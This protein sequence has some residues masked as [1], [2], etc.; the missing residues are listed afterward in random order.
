[1]VQKPKPPHSGQQESLSEYVVRAEPYFRVAVPPAPEQPAEIA[2]DQAG[3]LEPPACGLPVP[4]PVGPRSP[5][6][7]RYGSGGC[8]AGAA[9]MTNCSTRS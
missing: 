8:R 6:S 3:Q 5:I 1:M 2:R 7:C 9:V 4:P